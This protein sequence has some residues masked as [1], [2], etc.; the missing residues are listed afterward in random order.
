MIKK[1]QEWADKYIVF[2][3]NQSTNRSTRDGHKP[4]MIVDHI[5]EGTA[6]SCIDWFRSKNNKDSSAHFLVTRAGK[7][8][9]FVHLVDSA[10][11]NGLHTNQYADTKSKVVLANMG[12]SVNA[13]SVSIEHEGVYGDTHGE[14]TSEQL[15]SSIWLHAYI[16]A[17]VKDMYNV[18]IPVDPDH[19]LGHCII[20]PK[21]KPNCPGENFPFAMLRTGVPALLIPD[22]PSILTPKHW[23]QKYNDWLEEKC[24]MN[25]SNENFD[26]TMTRGEV[27]ALVAK[28]L[29]YK[30]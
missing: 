5:T 16:I 14:L 10:W 19:I 23:A 30:E 13:I 21:N 22:R 8:F 17:S 1:L 7:I 4:I 26:G 9:Q 20:N 25:I 3:G 2:C 28:A 24:G 6:Q 15:V 27:I 12:I 11:A 29:G 18:D